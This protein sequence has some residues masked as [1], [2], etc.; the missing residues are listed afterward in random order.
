[1]SPANLELIKLLQK[2]SRM[3]TSLDS[4]RNEWTAET[5]IHNDIKGD[6]I[7]V[8]R[9]A[10]GEVD[11]RII[12]W[13]LIQIGDPAW[14]VGSV[15]RDFLD[16]WLLSV[17]LTGDLN[18]EE[19]LERAEIPLRKIHPATRAFWNAYRSS[20]LM[21]TD[22]AGDFLMRALRFAAARMAQ[23]AYE[24]SSATHE[25]PNL[26]VAMLQLAA[27]ILEDTREASLHLFGIPIPWNWTRNA[28]P[29]G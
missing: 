3:T 10:G 22:Q 28:V 5:L 16:Y 24:W 23:G 6:N 17:P 13:E 26:S 11:V 12:D 14:D 2:N 4:L 27:N 25:P 1:M 21:Q 18:P 29:S 20:V 8:T 7:L 15:F 19:M 9:R